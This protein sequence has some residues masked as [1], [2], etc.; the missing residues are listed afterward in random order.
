MVPMHWDES[1]RV[2][3]VVLPQYGDTEKWTDPRTYDGELMWPERFG[4][5]EVKRMEDQLGIY[6]ASGRLEQM[7][8]PKGGG[9]IQSQWWLEWGTESARQYGLE[10][11]DTNKSGRRDFPEMNLV[12]ASVDTA[13]KEKEENDYNAIT[14]WGIWNDKAGN[15]R[16]MLMYAWR[17]RRPLHGVSCVQEP[18][19]PDLDFRERVKRNWG[20]V[21]MLADICKRYRVHR[22]L[23]E[24]KA[25]GHDV[26]GEINRLYARER[27]G[28]E[29]YE[30]AG[31]KVSRGHTI[32]PLFTDGVVWAPDTR[33]AQ[34]VIDECAAVPK[35]PNDDCFD[36][37]TQFLHWARE[38]GILERADEVTAALEDEAKWKPKQQSVAQQ[39]GV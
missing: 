4:E 39:Y 17:G 21:E 16:A 1:R 11:N 5:R 8:S 34:M 27:W 9:I 37:V 31:D 20:L 6:M 32:V 33:W 18:G 19:E 15:R 28:V 38:R 35:S 2:H 13:F 7:P 30:P 10:W 25:R 14:V 23:I 36:T 3:T 24:D 22:L 29:M 12:V 26:A